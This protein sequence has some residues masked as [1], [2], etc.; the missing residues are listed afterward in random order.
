MPFCRI[1]PPSAA[2]PVRATGSAP[3]GRPAAS[4]PA[5]PG[6]SRTRPRPGRTARPAAAGVRPLATPRSTAARR[7]GKCARPCSRAASQM[8]CTSACGT[9]TPPARLWVFSICTSV[10]D[11]KIAKLFGLIAASI[12]STREHA[13][14]A[15]L[16]DLHAGVRRRA[17]G[18]VPAGMRLARR[19]HLVARPREHAQRHLVGHRAGRQPQR[20]LLAEQLGDAR[21]Q[22]G[23]WSGLRRTGRRRPGRRPSRRASRRSGG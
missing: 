2:V 5:R 14:R 15:D 20:G 19:D 22:R 3:C 23:W 13:A 9:T 1:A 12:S 11:G 17:A 7:R 8:R 21:L 18:L 4:R 6:P 10:V 16:V